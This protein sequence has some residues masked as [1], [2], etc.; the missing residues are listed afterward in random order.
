MDM[1]LTRLKKGDIVAIISPSWGGPSVFP[2]IFK[3][4]ISILES[5]GLKIKIMPFAN[6]SDSRI[7]ENPRLRAKDIEDAF[8]DSEVKMIITSIGGDDGIRVL[9]Y[10]DLSIIKNNPKIFMGF[11]DATV[12]TTF[13]NQLGLI[14]FNGPSV[15]AGFSNL[16]IIKDEYLEYFKKFFFEKWTTFTCPKFSLFSHASSDWSKG[17]PVS[18]INPKKPLDIVIVQGSGSVKGKLF[19]GCIE[20]LEFMK[21]TKFW[22]DENFWNDKILFFETS[23]D[24]PSPDQI[25]YMLRNYATQGIL[26][27]INGIAFGIAKDYSDEENL[28]LFDVIRKVLAEYNLETLAVIANLQ[29]GHTY[30]Q[31]ILPLGVLA[32]INLNSKTLK[33]LESPFSDY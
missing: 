33:L 18:L 26:Q 9:E 31:F 25:K 17:L 4:G 10:I 13:F 29:F 1:K 16:D 7:Y 12:F 27:K 2:E 14:T 11:S 20:V 8:L 6:E 30:P 23:E 15:M 28:E 32:E 22:P 19:G 21:G 5:L 24:K 3:E